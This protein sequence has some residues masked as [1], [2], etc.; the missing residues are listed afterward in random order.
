MGAGATAA[1][2][3]GGRC[4]SGCSPTERSMRERRAAAGCIRASRAHAA[5]DAS[6]VHLVQRGAQVVDGH[7]QLTHLP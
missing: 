2:W 1:G 4:R 7:H 5:G 6:V 3:R